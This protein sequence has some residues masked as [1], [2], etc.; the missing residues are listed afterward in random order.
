MTIYL[1]N[2]DTLI[3]EDFEFKCTI[4]KKGLSKNK[5]EGDKKTP[6]GRFKLG[7]LYFRSDRIKKPETVI[8]SVP[9]KKNMG[10]CDDVKSKKFYNKLI[11]I[12]NK[13]RH[14]RLYRKDFKYDLFIPLS[15]NTNPVKI[16]KG[17]AIF[18][19]LTKNYKPTAGC[20]ALQ[21]KDFLILIKLLNKKTKIYIN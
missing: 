11:N 14:E 17:S 16:G 3:F 20:I 12:K 7:N 5:K 4:G 2:K 18:L 19:H 10:W 13:I 9:I 1:K 21:E 15:Y 8:K 6:T